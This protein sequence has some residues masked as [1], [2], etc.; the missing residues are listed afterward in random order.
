MN[1]RQKNKH[2][3]LSG[4][5]L[6]GCF[7]DTYTYPLPIDYRKLVTKITNDLGHPLSRKQSKTLKSMY[8]R[9][10][11]KTYKQINSLY[12]FNKRIYHH[13]SQYNK[14]KKKLLRRLM[15]KI[16]HIAENTVIPYI[17][18]TKTDL[19]SKIKGSLTIISPQTGT[20]EHETIPGG[21]HMRY[22]ASTTVF[23]KWKE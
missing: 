15:N 17:P 22:K 14:S 10:Y 21:E 1:K 9:K 18:R 20:E 13:T 6:K 3:L 4:V 11:M 7:R 8:R 12:Y 16:K 2:R 19:W 5:V 23:D